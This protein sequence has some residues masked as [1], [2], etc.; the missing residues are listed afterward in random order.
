MQLDG[1][2]KMSRVSEHSFPY[3]DPHKDEGSVQADKSKGKY[4]TAVAC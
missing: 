2:C 3:S 4:H 1:H